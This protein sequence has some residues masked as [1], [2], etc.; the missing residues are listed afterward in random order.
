VTR[1][2]TLTQPGLR[3]LHLGSVDSTNR[4][5]SEAARAGEPEGLVVVADLQTAGRGRQGRTWLAPSECG[6]TVSLLRRPR[7]PPTLAWAWTLI[8][9]LAT[10]DL[11]PPGGAWLKWPNDLMVGDRKAGGILCELVTRGMNLDAIVVGMGIN[12]RTPPGGWPDEIADRAAALGTLDSAL[13]NR[14]VALDRL[15][16]AYV[17]L[18]ANVMRRG[19]V[20]LV[21]AAEAA[22]A[23]MV[24]RRVR[25]DA[26]TARVV[27]I[28]HNGALRLMDEAGEFEV[29][30]GDVH[31]GG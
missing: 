27:G 31:L 12:L 11:A 25:V 1:G 15:C 23:P 22:M 14:Q 20:P 9:G 17:E 13:A 2:L 10:L 6:L 8:A 19:P 3:L 26:R 5:A 4:V 7:V 28:G 18:E 29:L 24:G 30:A 16:A 21:R